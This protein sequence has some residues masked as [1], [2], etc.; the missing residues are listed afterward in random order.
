MSTAH[1]SSESPDPSTDP[2][3]AAPVDTNAHFVASSANISDEHALESSSDGE[4]S[5]PPRAPTEESITEKPARRAGLDASIPAIVATIALVV[6]SVFIGVLG[7]RIG[8]RQ[9]AAPGTT[10]LY[11]AQAFSGRLDERALADLAVAG[12]APLARGNI[13]E[14]LREILGQNVALPA[15]SGWAFRCFSVNET[16]FAGVSGAILTGRAASSTFGNLAGVAILK[17]EQR[18]IVYDQYSRPIPM[19][20]GE[21]FVVELSQRLSEAIVLMYRERDLVFVVQANSERVADEIVSAMRL[22]TAAE[23]GTDHGTGTGTETRAS[24]LSES[25]STQPR[26]EK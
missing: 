13:E 7:P 9:A 8:N 17:H 22:A 25:P 1:D 21:V 5:T 24:E 3:A 6:F 14:R 26:P 4:A 20:E 10:L 19:P 16:R 15:S 12:N 2:L 11:L 18:L 23:H